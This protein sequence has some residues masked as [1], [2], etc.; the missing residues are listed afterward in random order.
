MCSC[1]SSFVLQF[2]CRSSGSD[3]TVLP[4]AIE[5]FVASS[6]RERPAF[7]DMYYSRYGERALPRCPEVQS[8]SVASAPG[9]V[10]PRGAVV[11]GDGGGRPLGCP[12]SSRLADLAFHGWARGCA[13]GPGG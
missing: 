7:A 12:R 1:V 9:H 4:A 6:L 10:S 11:R 5:T 8:R 2:L 13:R 3:I